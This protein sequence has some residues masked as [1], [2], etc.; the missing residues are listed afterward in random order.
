MRWINCEEGENKDRGKVVCAAQV[1]RVLV[2][3]LVR[4]CRAC[5]LQPKN[6][7]PWI[8]LL[9]KTF[10]MESSARGLAR[11]EKHSVI[12]R[13]YE[14]GYEYG[15]DHDYGSYYEYGYY[16]ECRTN[17]ARYCTG[18]FVRTSTVPYVL[19]SLFLPLTTTSTTAMKSSD[20]LPRERGR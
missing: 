11:R 3:A 18:I 5:Q 10:A 15:C 9:R 2:P 4:L 1:V 6:A 16:Y 17:S 20:F 19:C 13:W 12:H 8:G 7:K 14:Y